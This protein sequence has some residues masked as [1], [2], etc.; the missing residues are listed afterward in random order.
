MQRPDLLQV[1]AEN[2]RR[3]RLFAGLEPVDVAANGVDFTVVGDIT[4]RV[5]QIPGREGIGREAL[6]N[7]CQCRNRPLVLQ[8]V[9]INA[10][11]VS[12]QQSL[13]IDGACREGRHIEFLAVLQLQRFDGV[14]GAAANDVQ[15]ALEGVGDENVR[16]ATDEH[17]ADHR[18]LGLDGRRHRHVTVDRHIT[19]AEQHLA[20]SGDRALDF[21]DTGV[22]RSG[23]LRQEHH[24]NAVLAI[25]RQF[26]ALLGH[27]LA[28]ELVRNLDQD[29]G[30]IALQR[31]CADST[32][33]I[34]IF[35]DQQTLLDDAM[36]LLA[37]DVGDKAHAASVVLVGGVV[38]PLP[39]RY[40]RFHHTHSFR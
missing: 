30:T 37:L 18:L 15:L 38:Q 7:E 34:E 26:D 10:Y 4:E 17:L 21:F 35:Q 28:I 1:I 23:F 12:Q 5:R 6:V 3:D 13:V 16:T 36:V 33:V 9:V 14:G 27:F 8:V 32:A 11:L 20:F 22:T 25:R 19:P 31:I 24:A 39:I 40:C 2:R 29:T